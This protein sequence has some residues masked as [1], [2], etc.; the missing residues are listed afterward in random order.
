MFPHI[1]CQ[2]LFSPNANCAQEQGEAEV[3][4]NEVGEIAGVIEKVATV[5]EKVSEEVADTLAKNN[6]IKQSV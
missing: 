5:V 3:V 1:S 6:K 4:I 2:R